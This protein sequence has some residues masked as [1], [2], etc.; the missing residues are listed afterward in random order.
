[1]RARPTPRTSCVLIALTA[2]TLIYPPHAF[3]DE[4]L[5]AHLRRAAEAITSGDLGIAVEEY[6][7]AARRN[8]ESAD[9]YG[10]LGYAYAALGKSREA[11][12]AYIHVTEIDPTR[13]DAYIALGA[14]YRDSHQFALSID[15]YRAALS[16]D[17]SCARAYVGLGIVYNE[18]G[19]LDD[20]STAYESAWWTTCRELRSTGRV[21]I[22]EM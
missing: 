22:A 8:P 9:A 10:G 1:M 7:K 6:L 5:Y 18:L 17:P 11:A 21:W 16:R 15:T 2:L 12:A 13:I 19:R 14:A 4:D 20:A 3:T